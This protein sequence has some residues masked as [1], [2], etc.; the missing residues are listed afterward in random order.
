MPR[1]TLIGQHLNDDTT[2]GENL[3]MD[4][5]TLGNE[6]FPDGEN[7]FNEDSG[8]F[9]EWEEGFDAAEEEHLEELA[10]EEDDI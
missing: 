3:T 7:P 4:A 8:K 10:D 6:A 9:L 2:E 1:F 5:F